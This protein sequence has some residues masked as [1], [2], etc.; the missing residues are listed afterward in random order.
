[1]CLKALAPLTAKALP[2]PL[3]PSLSL[4]EISTDV[5]QTDTFSA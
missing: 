5:S 3:A 4:R 1:M 2:A